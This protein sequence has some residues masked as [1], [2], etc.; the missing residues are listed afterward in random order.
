MH[1]RWIAL[2]A[3]LTTGVLAW[4]Q[5]RP[6]MG[7]SSWNTFALRINEQVIKAQ[8]DAMVNNGFKEAGYNYLNI[9][10]GYFGGRDAEGNLLIHPQRFPNGMRTVVDYIHSKGLKAGIYSD[11]GKSTCGSYFGGDT[12][13]RNVGLYGHDK[14]D[15]ELFFNKLNFDF[16]KIDFCGGSPYHNP[17]K[18][19]L[20]ERDR[21]T[22][23]FRAIQATGRKDVRV[24]ACRWDYPGTW[25]SSVAGSWRTTGDINC[26]WR[27]VKGI[28]KQNLYLSAYA[29]KGHFN[30]MDMLEVGRGLTTEEDKTHF[31]M[32]C[33]MNSPLLIGCD[34]NKITE[35]TR[36]LLTN[37]ELIA[38]NQDPL[39][40]QAYIAA[41]IND[42]YLLV[43]DIERYQGRVRAIALYNPD[44]KAKQIAIRFADV[45]LSGKVMVRDLYARKDLGKY[46]T[47]FII[48]VPAHG[49]RIYRLEADQREERTN[50]EAET[51][52]ISD[53][54]ELVNNQSAHTGIYEYDPTC[55]GGMKATWL[56]TTEDNDLVWKQVYSKRGGDYQLTIKYATPDNRFMSVAVNGD[57]VA[58]V[59]F[60]P[61]A[62]VAWNKLTVNI[63]L[64][65]GDNIIR[66][67]NAGGWMPDIDCIQLKKI[68]QK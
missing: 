18:L 46:E 12:I 32:W 14:A 65:T 50:Y 62:D 66:L 55:S 40:Q 43:K 52:Y 28:L 4:P 11:A 60:S 19:R 22:D 29:S 53:Y 63:R 56:G 20:S 51:A 8:A 54:Q 15:C 49:T 25:I 3:F 21:Y 47:N 67:Y 39:C 34:M 1:K 27:S 10:D 26:S 30:D 57:K 35:D 68:T 6:L 42:C 38:L 16:I 7:W 17:E 2:A 41:Q 44:D 61:H 33:I 36:L 24:N 23:I 58:R 64:K 48:D 37:P 31:G 45:D 13:G 5:E 9:D 59:H